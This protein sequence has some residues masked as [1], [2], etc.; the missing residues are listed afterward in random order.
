MNDAILKLSHTL[1]QH[2]YSV[3]K[4]RQLVFAALLGR[5]P[6]SIGDLVKVLGDEVDRASVYRVVALF[7]RIGVVNRIQF[8]WKYKL[9]LSDSFAA[10]HHHIS[11]SVCGSVQ[12]FEES[13]TIS[14]ELKQLADEH[15]FLETGH[16]LE[17]RGIC[18]ICRAHTTP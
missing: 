9:E 12:S 2:G 3:T 14:F 1:K 10:H 5:E 17:I 7:E 15:G 6:L 4:S 16:Q 13:P 8:G 18:R 11:C